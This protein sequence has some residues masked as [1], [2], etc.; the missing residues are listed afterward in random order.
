MAVMMESVLS[1][2]SYSCRK[3]YTNSQPFSHP[4]SLKIVNQVNDPVEMSAIVIDQ[5]TAITPHNLFTRVTLALSI[6]AMDDHP[7]QVAWLE[8]FVLLLPIVFLFAAFKIIVLNDDDE[9]KIVHFKVPLP[10][11]CSPDWKGEVLEEP[12]VKVPFIFGMAV[13]KLLRVPDLGI[14]CHKMLLPS[15]WPTPR[16]CESFHA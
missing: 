11:Q 15:K 10:E 2:G 1:I 16:I 14:E 5:D 7:A 9:Q 4:T 12:T 6:L 3:S 13:R 8:I